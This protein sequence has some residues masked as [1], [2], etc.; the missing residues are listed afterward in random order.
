MTDGEIVRFPQ[1]DGERIYH[2]R[3]AGESIPDIATRLDM[4]TGEVVRLFR[5]YMV[6]MVAETSVSEREHL[7][8]MELDRLDQL[9][10]PFW[11]A[12]TEGEKEGA[13]VY[14]KIAAHRAKL[15]RL[16]Q[17]TPDELKGHAQIIVV[18]GGKEEYEEA[19]RAGREAGQVTGRAGDDDD[20]E[21]A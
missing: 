11:V 2:Y 13:E 5:E 4:T 6:Q 15:L 1:S 7:V 9:M 16:D 8:A 18:T 17:P 12:G 19:L 10:T 14:L 3:R 20:E 21:D